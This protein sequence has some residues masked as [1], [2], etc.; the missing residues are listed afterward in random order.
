[1][2]TRHNIN[3]RDVVIIYQ[4]DVD[5]LKRFLI[6]R[7]TT[8]DID[9]AKKFTVDRALIIYLSKHRFPVLLTH[10]NAGILQ[11]PFLCRSTWNTVSP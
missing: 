7:L 3:R 11:V 6:E 5:R 4:L 9:S 1:M 8:P 2:P 10:I